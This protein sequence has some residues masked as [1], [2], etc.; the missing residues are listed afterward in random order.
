MENIIKKCLPTYEIINRIGEGVNGVVY[1]VRDNLKERAVKVVPIMVERS[2][3]YKTTSDLD[4]KISHDFHAVQTYYS[5]IKGDGV[6]EIYDFHLVDKH[7]SK[8]QAK[9]YL[10]LLMQYCPNNLLHYVLD[11]YPLS[12]EKCTKLMRELAEV[13]QRLSQKTGEAFIVKDLKPSNLLLSHENKLLIGDLGGLQRLS[14]VSASARAQFTPNWSAPEILIRNENAGLASLIYSYGFVSYFTWFGALPYEMEDFN[15]RIRRIKSSGLELS[16][17]D[18]PEP[19][20]RL[21]RQCVSYTPENR[22]ADFKQIIGLLN[23]KGATEPRA[24]LFPESDESDEKTRKKLR[25]TI[26]DR[27][28]KPK[29]KPAKRLDRHKAGDIWTEPRTGMEFVWIP[30]GAYRMGCG[31]WDEEGNRDEFPAHEVY[32]DGFWMGRYPITQMQWKKVM[33][34]SL[35]KVVKS[36]NPSWFKLSDRHPVERVTWQDA[37]EFIQKLSSL[38]KNRYHFRLPT[39][40][41]WEY[42]ARSCGKAHKFAGGK[43]LDNLAWYYANSGLTTQP[44][45]LKQPNQ[46]G[47]YDMSGNIY[48]WCLDVY[49]EDAYKKHDH[50]NPIINN[51]GA[52]RIIRGGSYSNSAHEVRCTYRGSVSPD[53]KCNYIGFRVVMTPISQKMVLK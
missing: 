42:A 4:S 49:M 2:I 45:G 13:L 31:K 36:S 47:V 29:N 10:I 37:H 8:Q 30:S 48:E 39:E 16:R 9:A 5:K 1:H 38:N 52:R 17:P 6:V 35:W 21:L 11:N 40:A 33:S 15:E 18:I 44:V 20:G 26:R 23:G 14:S 32:I 12:P 34:S 53:F 27:Q 28:P 24:P 43:E 41:E 46:L 51:K 50:K 3:S 22:P 19:I 7:V 25:R